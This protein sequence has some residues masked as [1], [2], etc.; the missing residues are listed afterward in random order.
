MD[1]SAV[2]KW[3]LPEPWQEEALALLAHRERLAAPDIL[4]PE[5]RGV[6]ARRCRRGE[7]AEAEARAAIATFEAAGLVLHPS[8]PLLAAAFELALAARHGVYDCVYL[9][10]AVQL[11]AP[12]VT[13][14]EKLVAKMARLGM[15]V[16]L[17]PVREIASILPG[18]AS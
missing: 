18:A 12:L 7:V 17:V 11:D 1:A 4:A 9:A 3:F 14:D 5:L 16:R 6:L 10:L 2:A 15:P 13:G 8:P